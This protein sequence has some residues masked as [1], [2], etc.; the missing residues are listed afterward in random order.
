MRIPHIPLSIHVLRRVNFIKKPEFCFGPDFNPP[1]ARGRRKGPK[2]GHTPGA[3]G[4]GCKNPRRPPSGHQLPASL[5][6]G[7]HQSLMWISIV[8]MPESMSHR[9]RSHPQL[10]GCRHGHPQPSFTATLHSRV[11]VSNLRH[12]HHIRAPQP[13]HMWQRDYTSTHCHIT[14]PMCLGVLR[15][16]ATA[17]MR[18]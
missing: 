8:S 16:T 1:S 5:P 10:R 14:W 7:P 15:S 6:F 11:V 9:H 17:A 13:W 18:L 12:S 2:N 3:S 4:G